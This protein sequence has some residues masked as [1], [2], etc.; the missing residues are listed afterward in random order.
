MTE[1]GDFKNESDLDEELINAFQH[2]FLWKER[3]YRYHYKASAVKARRYLRRIIEIS[4]LK[5][6]EL[7]DQKKRVEQEQKQ[8][9]KLGT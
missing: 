4:D 9:K 7:L 2:Y 1:I 5:R 8:R 3:F 6:R